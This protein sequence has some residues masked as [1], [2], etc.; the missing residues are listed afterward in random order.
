VTNYYP[1]GVD[2]IMMLLDE[3]T[4][5]GPDI[6]AALLRTGHVVEIAARDQQR[7][8]T[9]RNGVEIDNSLV[10]AITP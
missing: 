3:A 4:P 5:T 10:I 6:E 2:A 9:T 7:E 8:V 1:G